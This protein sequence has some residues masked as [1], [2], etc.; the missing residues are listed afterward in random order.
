MQPD[1]RQIILFII[2]TTVLI[3]L[4]ASLIISMLYSYQKRLLVHQKNMASL[5]LNF[6]K[7]LLRTQIEIQEQTFQN[8]SRDIHDN[9]SL[10]LTLAKL[11]LNTLDWL[12]IEAAYRSVKTSAN[13]IGTAI[14]NLSN[15]SRS[16]N[17]EMIRSLGLIKALRNESDKLV[18]MAHLDVS[19]E[20][21]GEPV[22]MDSE[23]ELVVFRI[24]QEAFN[25]IIRHSHASKVWLYLNYN[26]GY[27]DILIKDNGNGFEK[28]ELPKGSGGAGLSNMQTRARMF[29]GRFTI[30]SRK[31]E[32]T[33]IL[34]TVPY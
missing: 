15:L 11:N 24:V 7:T 21:R 17:P 10:S 16:M 13:I 8:I 9:I 25:N 20:V 18:D 4:L 30:D 29:G 2:I 32:G 28:E 34:I 3:F 26:F 31:N 22:F 6:E 33:Q 5:K 19:Y 27:L 23:K 1:L 14:A 12:D